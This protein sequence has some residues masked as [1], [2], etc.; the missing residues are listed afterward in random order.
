MDKDLE[1]LHQKIDFLTEQVMETQRRQ[2]ELEELKQDL[3]PVVSDMFSTAVE[4]LEQVS[5]Y[6][7]SEDALYLLKKMMRNT[8]TFIAL[9]DTLESAQDFIQDAT[10]MSK[11]AFEAM[12]E[13]FDDMEKKGYFTFFRGA[14]GILD[15]IV[16]SFGEEDLKQLG[17]NIVL[18][19]NT[20]K[21]LTQPEMM[22][23]VQNAVGVYQHLNVNPPEK[24]SWF[25]LFREFRDPQV[26]RG[27]VAGLEILKNLSGNGENHS[28]A[29]D[30]DQR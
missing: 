30:S 11:A 2:R 8:R 14:M 21:Q 17:D 15:Q 5:P 20:V 7:T 4:E 23:T 9:L 1:S 18:I 3:T 25:A 24:I 10:P 26:R 6:F 19:L 13:T 16:T 28:L 27:L 29:T 22:T 12:L